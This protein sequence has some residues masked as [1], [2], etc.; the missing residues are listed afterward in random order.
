M[1]LMLDTRQMME[2]YTASSLRVSINPLSAAGINS[3]SHH[4]IITWLLIEVYERALEKT[5]KLD[6]VNYE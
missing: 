2:P 5:E 1:Q 6:T 3:T 4:I